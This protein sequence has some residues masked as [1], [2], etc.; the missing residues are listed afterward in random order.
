MGLAFNLDDDLELVLIDVP[1]EEQRKA[2]SLKVYGT[3]RKSDYI[4]ANVL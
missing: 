3:Y 4:F 2:W 1:T